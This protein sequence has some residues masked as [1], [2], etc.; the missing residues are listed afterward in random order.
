MN[1]GDYLSGIAALVILTEIVR[2]I[3]PN[4]KTKRA[5]EII[6]AL[7]VVIALITPILKI[8]DAEFDFG[9]DGNGFFVDENYVEE[10][11]IKNN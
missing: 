4:G 2:L 10:F 9:V 7:I 6:F 11:G 3:L 8:K 1:L 5:A